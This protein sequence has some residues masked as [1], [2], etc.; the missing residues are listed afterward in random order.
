MKLIIIKNKKEYEYYYRL[1]KEFEKHKSKFLVLCLRG[2]IE[3]YKNGKKESDYLTKIN[4]NMYFEA[5]K[6][7]QNWGNIIVNGLELR[8]FLMVDDID[9][10]DYMEAN[11]ISYLY[12]YFNDRLQM[13]KLFKDVYISENVTQVYYFR[14]NSVISDAI[15][16]VAETLKISTTPKKS[17][18]FNL[19]KQFA[20]RII[21]SYSRSR[22]KSN[23]VIEKNKVLFLVNL[24]SALLSLS[25]I[26]D[27][28]PDKLIV[29]HEIRAKEQLKELLKQGNYNFVNLENFWTKKAQG[30]INKF[31]KEYS[32]KFN[33][34]KNVDFCYEDIK[35]N[36][37][38]REIF[39]YFFGN[40]LFIEEIIYVHE[41]GKL[42][43]DSSKPSLVFG[44]DECSA[45]SKPIYRYCRKLKIPLMYLQNG[46]M[47]SREPTSFNNPVLDYYI[48]YGDITKKLFQS[49]GINNVYVTGW[50][51]LDSVINKR[52]MQEII[53]KY[54][55]PN[56]KIIL[57]PTAVHGEVNLPIFSSLIQLLF[58]N[59]EYFLIIKRHPGDQ[60]T[61]KNYLDRSLNLNDR[62][63]ILNEGLYELLYVCD[64]VVSFG[65]STI[66]EA[67]AFN[68]PV[69]SINLGDVKEELPYVGK[70]VCIEINN[71]GMIYE[72]ILS[73]LTNKE[74]VEKLKK[75]QN[76]FIK[77]LF[78]KIDGKS[79]ERV[80]NLINK[81]KLKT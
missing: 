81:Y 72:A 49:R 15:L 80:V 19:N 42:M 51:K 34:V 46:V 38:L 28:I 32:K 4:E 75:N 64:V 57:F 22:R 74:V 48:A 77:S 52:D 2:S 37:S 40:R 5:I 8:K 33:I 76:P 31:I 78:Y 14:D 23:K 1:I 66:L 25:P 59:P 3:Y 50:P 79:T 56:K 58:K 6:L 20:I 36:H 24:N 9:I 17:W 71:E 39:N 11:F 45:L 44:L 67:L 47:N 65:S 61:V 69:I 63:K 29:R 70:G 43:I 12:E 60:V 7:Y 55:L 35:L 13:V 53:D 16:D 27:K 54:K 68:K 21:R 18:K 73:V 41:V 10:W 62:I 30:K 26:L